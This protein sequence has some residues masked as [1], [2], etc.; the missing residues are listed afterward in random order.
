MAT[1]AGGD[2]QVLSVHGAR[3]TLFL[4]GWGWDWGYLLAV[5][6]LSPCDSDFVN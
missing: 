4:G 2:V 1:L 5:K 6:W 3:H